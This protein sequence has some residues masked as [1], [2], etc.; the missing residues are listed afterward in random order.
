[1]AQNIL[2]CGQVKSQIFAQNISFLTFSLLV[3]FLWETGE[4][5]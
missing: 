4:L 1:M 5:G 3:G 2:F